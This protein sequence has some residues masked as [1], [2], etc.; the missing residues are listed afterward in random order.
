MSTLI[1]ISAG[2]SILI[3]FIIKLLYY[4]L[5]FSIRYEQGCSGAETRW[6]AV[7][8]N[9]FKPE[10]HSDKYRWPQVERQH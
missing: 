7:L 2:N 10:W 6:N 4:S 5:V 9:I 3:I 1:L 8:A